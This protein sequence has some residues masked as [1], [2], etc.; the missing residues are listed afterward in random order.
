MAKCGVCKKILSKGGAKHCS[1][2]CRNASYVKEKT[3]S[4]KQ[5]KTVVKGT[6]REVA[7][8]RKFCSQHCVS[9]WKKT[10]YKGRKY[11]APVEVECNYCE[12]VFERQRCMVKERNYCDKRCACL[13]K[14]E[15]MMASPRC[16]TY[17]VLDNGSYVRSRWEAAFIRDYLIPKG[18]AW[19]YEPKTFKLS[20]GKKY[21]PDFYLKESDVYVEI[22][23]YDYRGESKR[24]AGLFREDT[25]ETLVYLDRHALE[26]VY[27]LN[28]KHNYLCGIAEEATKPMR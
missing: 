20:N 1:Y 6:S 13:D 4:C 25:G 12:K 23:G 28:L 21:T 11:V 27:G 3:F 7:K 19:E 15:K 14:K 26:S 16:R 5:C 22:K 8:T 9:E 17:R 24:R 18:I 10:A 2:V